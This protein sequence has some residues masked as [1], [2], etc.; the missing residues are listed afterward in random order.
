M[1]ELGK[2][3]SAGPVDVGTRMPACGI[4][5]GTP[6]LTLAGVLPVECIAPGDK[7]I[8]RAGARIVTAVDLAVVPEARVIRVA[9]GAF[10]PNRPAGDLHLSPR[11]PLLIR[12]WRDRAMAGLVRAVM[13]AEHL[14]DGGAICA[15]TLPQARMITLHFADPQVVFAGGLELGCGP[16]TPAA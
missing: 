15:E 3:I 8:T 6:I 14:V 12:D 4:A 5:C 16:A 1:A 10:G 13:P 9:Q 7:V 2:T 11:Q